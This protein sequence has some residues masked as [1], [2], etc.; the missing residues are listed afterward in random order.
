[1]FYGA[2]AGEVVVLSMY[3]FTDI[4]WLWLNAIGAIDVL[5]FSIILQSA[6]LKNRIAQQ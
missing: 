6:G 5:L 1:V 4:G 3:F 2:I